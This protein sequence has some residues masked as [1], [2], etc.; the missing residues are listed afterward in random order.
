MKEKKT[1][2]KRLKSEGEDEKTHTELLSW[3]RCAFY[4]W[5]SN[6][7]HCND[8]LLGR[9]S[10]HIIAFVEKL[11]NNL[12]FF[13]QSNSLNNLNEANKS[14]FQLGF[15]SHT[16]AHAHTNINWEARACNACAEM[17]TH[18]IIHIISLRCVR[19]CLWE[20]MWKCENKIQA[21]GDGKIKTRTFR[22]FVCKSNTVT[23][24]V[25]QNAKYTSS[26]VST[27]IIVINL[28]PSPDDIVIHKHTHI[29]IGHIATE[30]KNC[31]SESS[32]VKKATEWESRKKSDTKAS[33]FSGKSKTMISW[34]IF[35]YISWVGCG[36]KKKI[37][38]HAHTHT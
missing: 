9:C 16:L 1:K 28:G 26:P 10:F 11:S 21:H 12:S 23:G 7:C 18:Q 13:K 20:C 19:V 33:D 2:E 32:M 38:S 30:V 17:H 15:L 14:V 25:K 8:V 37:R 24:I 35:I 4:R 36:T 34:K 6:R 22:L 29:N 5:F 3:W 31:I 27:I